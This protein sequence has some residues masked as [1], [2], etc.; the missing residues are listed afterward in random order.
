MTP[1]IA[2]ATV[3]VRVPQSIESKAIAQ[4]LYSLSR[5]WLDKCMTF[6][7]LVQILSRSNF[8]SIISCAL[9]L[10]PWEVWLA[11]TAIL[12]QQGCLYSCE[13]WS[14]ERPH[15]F[16]MTQFDTGHTGPI[17]D[18]QLDDLGLRLATASDASEWTDSP[19]K[20][21][22]TWSF[23]V[24]LRSE[25]GLVK[26]WDVQSPEDPVF[27]CDLEGHN[28]PVH[29]VAWAPV[30]TGAGTLLLSGGSDGRVKAS[31]CFAR[32]WC[33]LVLL[34]SLILTRQLMTFLD[35][36]VHTKA[37]QCCSIW[38][39]VFFWN[40]FDC[41]QVLLWGPCQDPKRWQVVATPASV[42]RG[43]QSNCFFTALCKGAW[44][45][46]Q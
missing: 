6:W 30:G 21:G 35:C 25:D 8:N 15:G 37:D 46:P 10:W 24:E 45:E 12:L 23:D 3:G 31:N 1:F 32:S 4:K 43:N 29:Q 41:S 20:T 14:H 36:A 34:V 44:R 16:W 2:L 19:Q 7:A 33:F 40:L 38:A 22:D 26:L 27:L 42:W 13:M 39:C 11:F 28:G 9:Q 18:T 17:L 5:V